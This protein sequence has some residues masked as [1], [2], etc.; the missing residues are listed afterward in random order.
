MNSSTML[1]DCFFHL[2][3]LHISSTDGCNQLFTFYLED[4]CFLLLFDTQQLSEP[5]NITLI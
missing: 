1:R 5:I 3:M 4:I 2:L